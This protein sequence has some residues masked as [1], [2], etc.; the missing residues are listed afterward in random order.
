MTMT[1]HCVIHSLEWDAKEDVGASS[2]PIVLRGAGPRK[3]AVLHP[4]EKYVAV[5]EFW[6]QR[7]SFAKNCWEVLTSQRAFFVPVR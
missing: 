2:S 4:Q 1:I 7:V 5:V 3:V 6:V